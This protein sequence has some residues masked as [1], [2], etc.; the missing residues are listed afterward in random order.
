[1]HSSKNATRIAGV[2]SLVG[3]VAG[4]FSIVY[5][6][7]EPDYLAK[8]PTNESQVF[9]GAFFQLLMVPAY[10]G[11][12]LSLYPILKDYNERLALGFVGF[13]FVAAGFHLVGVI[14]LPIFVYL[15]RE[16]L[17]AGPGELTYLRHLG[18]LLR[19][20][21]DLSNHV[22]MILAVTFGGLMYYYL[23]FQAR[24]VPRWLSSWGFAGTLFTMTAS[25]LVLLKVAEV[26]STEYI[27]MNAPLALNE[28]LL[29]IWL[30][31]KG[32]NQPLSIS[33]PGAVVGP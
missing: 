16:A 24:L 32:F 31:G 20:T 33:K 12:A 14:I 4:V 1:M 11:V 22:G 30:I 28:I 21:R 7:E 10:V 2:F 3:I 9:V 29:A 23:L 13:R 17:M 26:V 18:E 15:G 27:V 6:I 5:V 8:L 25:V 19:T